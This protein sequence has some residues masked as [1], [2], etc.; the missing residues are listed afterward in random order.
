M[1][2]QW[3]TETPML[4]FRC[5]ITLPT[6]NKYAMIN[7]IHF[8]IVAVCLVNSA[9]AQPLTRRL[10]T[11]MNCVNAF[12]FSGA[13]LVAKADTILINEGYG[14]ADEKKKNPITT[15]TFFD[16]GSYV[17]AFTATAIMQL[18]EKGK[19]KVTDTITRFF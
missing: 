5:S 14:W 6:L 11:F 15:R 16:I 2:S 18:E 4:P 7:K 8:L 1:I 13:V 19:L 17:K 10:E 12:G 9:E 3:A